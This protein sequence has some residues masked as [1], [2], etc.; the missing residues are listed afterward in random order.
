MKSKYI[1]YLLVCTMTIGFLPGCEEPLV[2]EVYSELAPGNY[3]KTEEGLNSVLN[4]AYYYS[5][6]HY[7]D[8]ARRILTSMFTAGYAWGQGGGFE[9][10]VAIPHMNFTWDS[11]NS[12]YRFVW[13][14]A[15]LAIRNANII[16]DNLDNAEFSEGKKTMMKAEAN[17]LRGFNYSLL[18]RLFGTVPVFISTET[19]DLERGR[20]SEEELFAVI[21][22][23][24]LN[25]ANDL[26]LVQDEFGRITKGAA[27]AAL[28]K[29]YLQTKQWDKC[30]DATKQIIESKQYEL[31]AEYK[32]IFSLENEQ[33]KEMIWV[34]PNQTA[35]RDVSQQLIGLILPTD[36]PLLPNQAT[37]AAKCYIYDDFIDSFEPND[38]RKDLFVQSY[39]NKSGNTIVGY[40]NDK[41]LCLKFEPDPNAVSVFNGHDMPEIRYADILLTRAEALNELNGPNQETIDLIN[42]VRFRAG[43]ENVLLSDFANKD[44]LNELILLERSHELYFEAKDREDLIRYDQFIDNAKARGVTNASDHHK[45]YPIPQV[46]IDA[47]SDLDQNE[48]Y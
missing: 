44:E 41:S 22:N 31:V 40:G 36:Y 15:Y 4:G 17:A 11:N 10:G 13:A 21:E 34:H 28:S 48:G 29:F 42:Q 35:P 20:A 19:T 25:A 2:E 26:P 43:L 8:F 47:N 9:S 24:L 46:E 32:N 45:L 33:N 30:V 23:D 16:L 27:L 14:D 3:L 6:F 38:T 5:Q 7:Q 39:V 37:W 18:Y 12:Y 1:R